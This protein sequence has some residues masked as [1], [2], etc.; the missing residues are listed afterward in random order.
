MLACH[1]VLFCRAGSGRVGEGLGSGR[2]GW[3]TTTPSCMDSIS[4]GA[5]FLGSWVVVVTVED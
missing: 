3:D 4:M 2:T 1:R 5:C